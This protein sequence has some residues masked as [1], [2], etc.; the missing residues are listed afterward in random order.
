MNLARSLFSVAVVAA[1]VEIAVPVAHAQ[2][3]SCTGSDVHGA[4]AEFATGNALMEQALGEARAGRMD[5]ARA[6]AAEALT[7]FDRQCELGDDGALAERGTALML[8]GELLRSAQT[9][10]AFLEAHPL[11]SM[12]SRTR[13]RIAANLQPGIVHVSLSRGE[14]A[15]FVDDLAFGRLP[16]TTE[17]RLP[18]GEHRFEARAPDGSVIATQS[19]VLGDG[20]LEQTVAL[21]VVDPAAPPTRI[22]RTEPTPTPEQPVAPTPSPAASSA[23]P[24]S[25]AHIDYAGWYVVTASVA[26][27][28]LG[29]GI[30]GLV[31]SN[32]RASA[33]NASCLVIN[34]APP[35]CGSLQDDYHTFQDLGIGGMIALGLGV[36]G[37]VTVIILDATQPRETVRIGLAPAIGGGMLS[38]S[39][40][41]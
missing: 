21:T 31:V 37:L 22:T 12:D 13:R 9:Y 5:R 28:G 19:I 38:A 16:R 32:D 29:V 33:F 26:A 15:L 41:F 8:M 7:H 34:T 39:G 10:D 30:A 6:R 20:S 23:P 18:A 36:V 2:V 3:P 1:C 35:S 14:A 24:P 25:S 17:L 40:A 11:A 27:I 4:S